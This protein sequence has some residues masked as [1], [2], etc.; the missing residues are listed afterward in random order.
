M[1]SLFKPHSLTCG[2]RGIFEALSPS[3][4]LIHR[5][6][7][8]AKG[9]YVSLG[10]H[11]V[12]R[13]G[14]LQHCEMCLVEEFTDIYPME[15]RS[16]RVIRQCS[17]SDGERT[18]RNTRIRNRGEVY[19]ALQ[20][21]PNS[22]ESPQWE[23][24]RRS[25]PQSVRKV[26]PIRSRP[27]KLRFPFLRSSPEPVSVQRMQRP[28]DREV[29]LDPP[30]VRD[31]RCDDTVQPRQR[32][33]GPSSPRIHTISPQRM[34]G[35][36]LFE[37]EQFHAD[38]LSREAR[39]R[40]RYQ[41]QARPPRERTPVVERVP[42]RRKEAQ[43][44]ARI[45]EVHNGSRVNRDE[46]QA[47]K[48]GDRQVRFA[49]TIDQERGISKGRQCPSASTETRQNHSLPGRYREVNRTASL[50]GGY[51]TRRPYIETR[52]PRFERSRDAAPRPTQTLLETG[53]P[54]PRIIQ[55]GNRHVAEA[56]QRILGEARRR[57]ARERFTRDPKL[58]TEWRP[59]NRRSE[60]LRGSDVSNERIGN[61][62]HQESRRYGWRWRWK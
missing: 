18:C 53:R 34:A 20:N 3:N 11:P 31:S 54:Q 19:H 36:A 61:D 16:R 58:Y 56:G 60:H 27:F 48:R 39:P 40:Q 32:I 4:Y 22:P 10:T 12:E 28:G 25:E 21:S 13:T 33:H 55:D 47:R 8:F 9:T 62:E 24:R 51:P 50:Q 30:A 23:Y 57:Q 2:S 7:S 15:I 14:R 35:S 42:L 37:K 46:E 52:T 43:D 17:S 1:N 38:T 29:A 44:P 49:N 5:L 6:S 45:V 41:A 59:W 26:S